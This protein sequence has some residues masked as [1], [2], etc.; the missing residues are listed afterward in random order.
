MSA[1]AGLGALVTAAARAAG[2]AAE[3]AERVATYAP[4]SA[5]PSGPVVAALDLDRTLVYSARAM[6]LTGPD[7]RAPRLVVAEVYQREPLSFLTRDAERM[8]EVLA[9]VAVMVPTTTRTR[10]QYERIVLPGAPAHFAIVANGGRLLVDGVPD[11]DWTSGVAAR[12]AGGCAPIGEVLAHLDKVTD[13]LWLVKQRVAEDLFCY[14]VVDRDLL[15]A[16]FV[17]DLTTWCAALGW[18]VSLQGRKVYCVP[19]PL[20]KTAAVAEVRRRAGAVRVVAAGDSLLDA[21]MLATADE[22]VRP[23]HGELHDTGWVR[24][25]VA[26]TD[27]SGVLGGE[28]LVARVLANVLASTVPVLGGGT[29]P[30]ESPQS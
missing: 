18:T 1:S 10:E 6:A 27:R 21:E 22:G 20:T 9:T 23:A 7:A 4:L 25:H 13:P 15:P 12:L 8:L 14:L 26:V 28:E 11:E 17:A 19:A 30:S 16:G 5:P 2:L 24:P 29:G 3:L